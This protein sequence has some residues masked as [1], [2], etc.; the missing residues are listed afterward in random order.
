MIGF[1]KKL[2]RDKRGNA[3]V[4]IGAAL[5][6]VI[7]SAGLASDT[8]QWALWKR[9]LQRAADSGAT[10]GVY[11]IIQDE[12]ARTNVSTAVD[13]D[14]T[15]N[16]HIAYTYSKVVGAPTSGSFAS[17]PY[18]VQVQ[19]TV[20]KA[21]GFSGM[22]LNY[23]PSIVASATAT[24]TPSGNYCVVSLEDTAATG[25]TMTGN[26]TVNLGCG[27]ITNSTSMTAAVATGSSAVTSSPIAAVGGIAAS[28]NW[29][30]GTVL[31]PF[32]VAQED[33]FKNV[34]P[35]PFP[36]SGSCPDLNNQPSDS[37][38]AAQV[39]SQAN[40]TGLPSGYYCFNDISIQGDVVFPD[41][42]VIILDGGDFNVNSGAHVSCPNRCTF[43]LSS[44]DAATD[45]G[46]IGNVDI[47]G[48]AEMDLIANNTGDYSGLI[49][50]QDRRAQDN[51]NA[52]TTNHINGNS[53]SSFTGAFYFPGQ[54]TTVNGSAGMATACVKLVARRVE[55][56]G[57]M[58]IS[59]TCPT[60]WGGPDFTGKK[61]RLVA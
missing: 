19:L 1:F 30:T 57:N 24:V 4:I 36:T 21:L 55:F 25:I 45:P 14:L 33:P 17:D 27:M 22:F 54:L 16:N 52:N 60:D 6:L 23:T 48:G 40:T 38:T 29:G 42:S 32:T 11:A 7:G 47:N 34:A 53:D 51:G 5:P 20:Q 43:V 8:I 3:L 2:W 44:R 49:F 13:K 35:P 18:A 26:A 37:T 10:A 15:Y 46:S 56:S 61:V 39:A 59:N 58:N 9:Q 28:N 31:Q 12:G 50:Y 41:N